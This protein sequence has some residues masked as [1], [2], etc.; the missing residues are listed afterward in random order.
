MPRCLARLVGRCIRKVV[1]PPIFHLPK[2]RRGD[3]EPLR[4]WAD[5][6]IGSGEAKTHPLD[7]EQPDYYILTYLEVNGTPALRRSQRSPTWPSSFQLPLENGEVLTATVDKTKVLLDLKQ[8]SVAARARHA[9][10]ESRGLEKT[11]HVVFFSVVTD[12]VLDLEATLF[13]QGGSCANPRKP[14]I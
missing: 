14:T 8:R 7:H 3:E 4:C 5:S 10:A 2:L 13:C 1:L 9:K 11:G 12:F 6:Y